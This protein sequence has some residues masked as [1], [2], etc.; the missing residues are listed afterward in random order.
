MDNRLNTSVISYSYF[1]LIFPCSIFPLSSTIE[2][3]YSSHESWIFKRIVG[4]RLGT[5]VRSEPTASHCMET[6]GT[7]GCHQC[8]LARMGNWAHA[9]RGP[10]ASL[11]RDVSVRQRLYVRTGQRVARMGMSSCEGLIDWAEYG[12][13][14][15]EVR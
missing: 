11:C 12:Q 10:T 9:R 15:R 2:R 14:R 3:N 5:S 7:D 4:P 8:T 6:A 13:K 1:F